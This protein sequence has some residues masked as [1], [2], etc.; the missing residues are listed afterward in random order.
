MTKKK[1]ISNK[2]DDTSTELIICTNPNH[3][4]QGAIVK[5]SQTQK[6]H[7]EKNKHLGK[8]KNKKYNPKKDNPDYDKTEPKDKNR[9]YFIEGSSQITQDILNNNIQTLR[10]QTLLKDKTRM[11]LVYLPTKQE[12]T[13]GTG[14][15]ITTTYKFLNSAYFVISEKSN[16]KKILPFNDK[17][18]VENYRIKVLS[19]WNDTRWNVLDLKKWLTEKTKTNPKKLYELINDTTRKY[20]EF[21]T[22]SEYTKFNLWNIATYFFELFESF[23]YN[24]Y[25]GIK[26]AGKTK[27]L[28]YQKLVCFNSV[29][30][31]DITSSA[32]FRIIEG[33]GSTLLLDETESFKDKKNEQAQAVRNI[34]MQGYLRNQYAVRNE[35]TKDKN[36]TPT[37][38]NLYS[39]KSMA[40]ISTFDDTLEE[41]C[42]QQILRRALDKTV[43]NTW[44]SEEDKSFSEIR[45]LCYRL[46]VDYADEINKLKD[47]ARKLLKVNS[48]ELQLWT[49]IITLALFFK[50]HG[51]SN[52]INDIQLSV[53]QSS[54]NRQIDDEQETKELK[55]LLFLD[56]TGVL[57]AQN[58]DNVGENPLYWIPIS[59][60]FHQLIIK[61]EEYEIPEWFTRKHLTEVL[62]KFG[63]IQEKKRAGYSWFITRGE[64]DK[65]KQQ[66][67]INDSDTSLDS[68]DSDSSKTTSQGSQTSHT[69]QLGTESTNNEKS[70]DPK[71]SQTTQNT[72]TK[73]KLKTSHTSHSKTDSRRKSEVN[74]ASEQSEAK[75]RPPESSRKSEQSEVSEVSKNNKT[76]QGSQYTHFKCITCDAGNFG[77]D[78]KGF[79]H[80]SILEFHKKQGHSIQYFNQKEGGKS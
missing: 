28:L 31:A 55:V 13:K 35:T 56:K 64:V 1:T 25:T 48:R 78:A 57:L 40:H 22:E 65:V 7:I 12:I 50:N 19:E 16:N 73:S 29:M 43:K 47:E 26:R 71:T 42:I 11:V 69:S 4:K 21:A 66:V 59:V 37:Q 39:P 30:S 5:G 52:L 24:D 20:L 68:F 38:Y 10:P 76:S 77:I 58:K 74:E 51:I 45:N 34:L 67:G 72:G 15:N 80:E 46:F 14:E 23:P 32:T 54:T 3:E 36:F 63:F 9:F 6:D 18:L 75:T 60:L 61:S 79:N 44:C 2:D 17:Q 62:R 53:S 49:P 8:C 70:A 33:I 27:S 41:R